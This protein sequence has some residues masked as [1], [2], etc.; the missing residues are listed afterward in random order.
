[1][2]MIP[3]DF[4]FSGLFAI[5]RAPRCRNAGQIH[6]L[7][8]SAAGR[9]GMQLIQA[10]LLALCLC[11]FTDPLFANTSATETYQATFIDAATPQ[12]PS[13]HTLVRGAP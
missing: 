11:G 6:G 3:K 13:A 2:L 10:L 12:C 9:P 4:L 5:H 1:M 8:W 7:W